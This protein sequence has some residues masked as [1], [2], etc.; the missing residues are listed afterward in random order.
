MSRKGVRERKEEYTA[1]GM[2][3]LF[4]L[5]FLIFRLYP[6]VSTFVISF[7]DRNS[8]R[9]V[10]STT[11][12]GLA[13][14]RSVFTN[15]ETRQA[16]LRTFLYSGMYTVLTMSVC[17]VLAMLLNK[18][19]W[20]RTVVRTFF[21]MPYV[22][23]LIAIGVVWNYL[24]NPY[25]G[26]VNRMLLAL[27]IPEGSL[28][29]WLGSNSGALGTAAAIHTWVG[30]AF[31][32]ITLIA[33]LQQVPRSFIE[34]AELEGATSFQRVRYIVYPFIRPT[35]IFILTLTVIN[36]FK[37]YT[38]IMALTEGGPGTATQVISLKI[39]A[40]AFKYFKLGSAAAQGSILA[41]II[42]GLNFLIRRGDRDEA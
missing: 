9:N 10:A 40:D 28:P 16:F 8:L 29:L 17:T 5:F 25:R 14:Y 20:G 6:L 42:F 4:L 31:P 7:L 39:Y 33:S 34:V 38:V 3:T 37:N 41:I 13:N 1:F 21:Y 18:E 12:V 36:S 22:T 19:F 26:P 27:G 2:L 35:L 15:A 24:L 23:N 30:M 11:F 32:I